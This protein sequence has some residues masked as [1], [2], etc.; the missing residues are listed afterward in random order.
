MKIIKI[1]T[2]ESTWKELNTS[3]SVGEISLES[4]N[5]QVPTAKC[6]YKE[7][8]PFRDISN[9]AGGGL[10]RQLVYNGDFSSGADGWS[11]L[12]T[13]IAIN[14]GVI[15]VTPTG[16][17]VSSDPGIQQ[18]SAIPIIGHK[19]L[20][21]LQ[22][23][24]TRSSIQIVFGK[25]T[26]SGIQGLSTTEWNTVTT[27]IDATTSNSLQILTGSTSTSQIMSYKN[28][29]IFDLTEIFGA[30]KESDF[31]FKKRFTKDFYPYSTGYS[32]NNMISDIWNQS[33]S[34]TAG[35]F[36]IL[37][38]QL[39]KCISPH[40]AQRPPN[41]TY[42]EVTKITDILSSLLSNTQQS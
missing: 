40:S 29:N 30:G 26:S 24:G 33:K 7:L 4:T 15:T 5:E 1:K 25:A 14:D 28:I 2:D 11:C 9:T 22:A 31:E 12:N 13:T 36:C 34:Y 10:W 20:V 27:V 32:S 41:A 19:Y 16:A 3:E 6:L 18:V 17:G 23:L 8:R 35:Q 21:R 42:W 37:D 39:Y 38:N